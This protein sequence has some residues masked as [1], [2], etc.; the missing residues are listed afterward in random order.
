MEE[1]GERVQ[2]ELTPLPVADL[3]TLKPEQCGVKDTDSPHS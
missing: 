1:E 2:A 3:H